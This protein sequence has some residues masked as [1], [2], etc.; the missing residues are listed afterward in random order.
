MKKT[1]FP[2]DKLATQ[3]IEMPKQ[4]TIPAKPK[5][6]DKQKEEA[7]QPPPPEAGEPPAV[8]ITLENEDIPEVGK[9][10]KLVAL[11]T[12][13]ERA[14]ALPYFL[15][16][17]QDGQEIKLSAVEVLGQ[18]KGKRKFTGEFEFPEPGPHTVTFA[19]SEMKYSPSV[20]IH[21]EEKSSGKKKG[22]GGKK[23]AKLPVIIKEITEPAKETDVKPSEFGPDVS[24][25]DGGGTTTETPKG[26]KI[27]EQPGDNPPKDNT[28]Y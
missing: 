25:P 4:E 16:K 11:L 9:P 8:D 6:E 5:E 24:P 15:I 20:R 28:W 7:K 12:N 14:A 26:I 3:K 21:I 13:E 22:K 2:Y 10:V 19:S 18:E 1:F 23:G 17:G 27:I